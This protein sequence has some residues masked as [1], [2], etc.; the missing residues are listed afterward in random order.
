M[1]QIKVFYVNELRVCC[2]LLWDETKEAILVDPGCYSFSEQERLIKFVDKEKL[3]P[4]YVVNTHAHF[5]HV[6]GNA[7]VCQTWGI[8]TYIHTKEQFALEHADRYCRVFGMEIMKPP[9]DTLP[10]SETV[11][12]SFG[13][14]TLQVIETPGHSPGGICL[15]APQAGLPAASQ[16]E[17]GLSALQ[18]GGFAS[19][20]GFSASQAGFSASQAESG[21]SASQSGLSASQSGLSA[22]DGSG[23]SG[24]GSGGFFITGDTLFAGS[25]GR[26][27]LPGGDYD[28]LIESIQTK[29][30]PLDDSLRILPGHGPE[31]TLGYERLHNPFLI[32][33]SKG[34][35]L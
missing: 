14:S 32:P 30:F 25:I 13:L 7:F 18:A 15:Y 27:D 8:K 34:I 11:P 24:G 3:R 26:T 22:S 35:Y 33:G 4:L 1:I 12:L 31:S 6:M 29:L 23:G 17:A 16:A 5:D 21:L 9:T 20:S 19:Q 2:Y 28:R 10:L